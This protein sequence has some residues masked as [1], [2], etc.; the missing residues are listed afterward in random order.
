MTAVPPTR[1]SRRD[2]RV[3][4]QAP[5]HVGPGPASALPTSGRPADF[6]MSRSLADRDTQTLPASTTRPG[7]FR[8]LADMDTQPQ[9]AMPRAPARPDVA[10]TWRPP[11]THGRVAPHTPPWLLRAALV[12]G[13]VLIAVRGA[14][15]SAGFM[16]PGGDIVGWSRLPVAH[17]TLCNITPPA[18]TDAQQPVTPAAYAAV[19]VQHMSL[20][21]E[22]GQMMIVQFQ[23]LAPSPDAVQM[24]N[25]QGAGGVLFFAA[26]IQSA[27]QIRAM[28]AQL[29]QMAAIPL[30]LSVDQ[31]G[32]PVN[33]FQGIVGTL[34]AAADVTS[35]AMARQR[36][37]QDAAYLHEYGF[38]LNLAPVVDV[39]TA[40]P[41]LAGRT[42]GSSPDRVAALAGAYMQGL[43]QS[44]Q[45]M[46]CLKHFP[47]LG[48][49]TTDPH[50]GLPVLYRSRS[51]WEQ[52]DLAPYRTLL[53]TGAVHAIMVSHEMIPAVDTQLPSTLSPAIVGALRNDLGYDGVLITDS[54]YMGALNAHWSVPEAAV[55]AVKA[56]ADI[57]IGPYSPQL[58][59]DTRD[60]LSQA[61]QNGT[62]TRAR[63]DTSVRRILTLK[64][65][66][67]L[68]PIPQQRHG[69][70]T[71]L[72]QPAGQSVDALRR[73]QV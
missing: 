28:N 46:A 73:E 47:G 54:L 30:L 19:L 34:P 56:G 70:R 72:T 39:G 36:G 32:G 43:Q 12:A 8:A 1:E 61:I 65:Q 42:F 58:V 25:V 57:V 55:L 60:A 44:G 26:N 11:R 64:I 14:L 17:C 37:E 15:A 10:Q 2:R 16:Q 49:T 48:N 24:I 71:G 22:L 68:I 13:L 50:I 18:P 38:N 4:Q 45:V 52:I 51:Q 31:E 40:N 59:Q 69:V 9:V 33:R 20:N 66:M 23:G 6:E 29:Q 3:V 21:D 53:K 7:T 35:T 63:I 5:L 41:Q 27:S 67:G 62:L